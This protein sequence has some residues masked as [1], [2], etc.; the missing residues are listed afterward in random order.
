[1]ITFTQKIKTV[2]KIEATEENR[3]DSIRRIA[4][5]KHRKSDADTTRNG[6]PDTEDKHPI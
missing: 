1:M 6:Y 4:A 5:E 3:F 2:S